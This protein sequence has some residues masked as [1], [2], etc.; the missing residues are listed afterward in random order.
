M[1]K[2][3]IA[4]LMMFSL[5]AQAQKFDKEALLHMEA[6]A[7]ITSAS[8]FAVSSAGGDQMQKILIPI[9]VQNTIGIGKEVWDSTKPNNKFSFEDIM[10]NNAGGFAALLLI[11]GLQLI[12]VPE[13]IA[14][15]VVIS[16]S[17]TS[18]GLTMS[19]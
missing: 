16:A 6:G 11:E 15:G 2:I 19:F 17:V 7:L 1:K 9:V 14:L 12:G 18:F 3:L 10:Y 13:N 4:F 5:T 8:Y